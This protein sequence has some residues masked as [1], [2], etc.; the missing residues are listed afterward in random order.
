VTVF[1]PAMALLALALVSTAEVPNHEE[2]LLAHMGRESAGPWLGTLISIDAALVLSG[3]VL[4]SYVGVN[5]LIGRMTLDRCLPQFLLKQS[6]RGTTHRILIAFFLLTVSVL[7]ITR[8]ELEAL[9]G[10]YTLSFLGVMLLFT[11]GNVL[12]KIKRS[13]LPRP[14]RARWLTVIVAMLAVTTGLVGNAIMNPQYLGVFLEYFFAAF[15]VVVVMLTRT[16]L[17]K[18]VLYVT[19]KL[20]ASLVSPMNRWTQRMRNGIESINAQQVVFFTRGDNIANLNEVMQYVERNE[21]T[22][23]IKIVHVLGEGEKV[24]GHLEENLGFLDKAY[25]QIDI[26]FVSLEGVFGPELIEEL[27]RKWSIPKNFMFIGCPGEGM[28]HTLAELGGVRVIV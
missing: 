21:H 6:R 28:S 14:H 17:L 20:I 11:V 19:R 15:L 13:R 26:E 4:T 2:A 22:S 25:P 16:T 18:A 12:L 27:S 5:G 3:A 10:V 9:A 24:P 1:N 7:L 23:R 8:G